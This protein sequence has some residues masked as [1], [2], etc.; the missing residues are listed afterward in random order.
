[1]RSPVRNDLDSK[2]AKM[3]NLQTG[4]PEIF[5]NSGAHQNKYSVNFDGNQIVKGK[6]AAKNES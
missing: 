3:S 6:K 5:G 2:A 1:M 4:N